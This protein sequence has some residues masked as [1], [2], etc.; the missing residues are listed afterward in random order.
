M[1]NTFFQKPGMMLVSILA[2][3]I[4]I[5]FFLPWV[6]VRSEQVGKVSKLLT[7]RQ[8]ST[9]DSISGFRIPILANGKDARLMINIIKIFNPG[10]KNADKKSFLVWV[11]PLLVLGIITAKYLYGENQWL[12]LGIGILGCAIFLVAV[13]KIMTTD[14]DKFVLK[15]IIG[16]G[17]W[18]T[19]LAYLGIGV[20][21]L[22][23]FIKAKKQ[24]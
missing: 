5:S 19:L 13:F 9:I 12:N 10:V 18:F 11:I 14:M 1:S 6:T 16:P 2:A 17:L 24:V 3:I 21:G 15:V 20:H 23:N 7:G 22:L 4:I 8:Q